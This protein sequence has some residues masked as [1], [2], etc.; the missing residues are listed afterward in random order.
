MCVALA[1][2]KF[3]IGAVEYEGY[4]NP[5]GNK[6][7][8]AVYDNVS[9]GA[10]KNGVVLTENEQK[11]YFD[12]IKNCGFNVEIWEKGSINNMTV[13]NKWLPY[14]KGKDMGI[15]LNIQGHALTRSAKPYSA[16]TPVSVLL[17]DNWASLQR[18]MSNHSS[19]VNWGDIG[20]DQLV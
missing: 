11:A 20:K 7:P 18:V 1:A 6:F 15:I 13:M 9:M 10:L 17:E 3:S 4:T 12:D 2:P 5:A 16:N 8:I 14:I 19:N